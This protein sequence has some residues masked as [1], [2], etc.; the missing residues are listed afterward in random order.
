[1]RD[2]KGALDIEVKVLSAPRI[3]RTKSAI[4]EVRVTSMYGWVHHIEET[5]DLPISVVDPEFA[6]LFRVNWNRGFILP[7]STSLQSYQKEAAAPSRDK[8]GL[9]ESSSRRN[10]PQSRCAIPQVVL[11]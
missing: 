6:R 4:V 2:L 5:T 7:R 3:Y 11:A 9:R 10:S 8:N 1:M